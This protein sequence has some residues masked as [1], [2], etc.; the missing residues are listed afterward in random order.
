MTG[1]SSIATSN[2]GSPTP[3]AIT[4]SKPVTDNDPR[5]PRLGTIPLP[6]I[7]TTHRQGYDPHDIHGQ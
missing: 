1:P 4:V 2:P 6:A 3:H 7:D 5:T